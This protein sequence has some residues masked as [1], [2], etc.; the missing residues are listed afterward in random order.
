MADGQ[1]RLERL[2]EHRQT[3]EENCRLRVQAAREAAREYERQLEELEI[4]L[5]RLQPRTVRNENAKHLAVLQRYRQRLR[6][7]AERLREQAQAERER[8][9]GEKDALTSAGQD[10]LA[11][12]RLLRVRKTEE[13]RRKLAIAQADVDQ[14]GRLR[15]MR[16]EV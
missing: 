14:H 3:V 5:A 1:D 10:R 11:V 16:Q 12:E 7:S 13:R 6:C 9:N 15:V 2:F 4:T 8:L